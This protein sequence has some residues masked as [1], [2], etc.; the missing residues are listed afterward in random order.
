MQFDP[1]SF[2]DPSGRVFEHDGAVYRTLSP[3]ARQHFETAHGAGLIASLVAAGLLIETDLVTAA[4]LG[5]SAPE[6]GAH[7]LAQPRVPVVT[8]SYEWSFEMLRDAALVTLRVIDRALQSGYILKDATAF[9]VLFHGTQPQFIDIL[10]LEPYE[11]GQ[12]WTGYGQFCRSFLFPLLLA[13]YRDIDVRPLLQGTLGELPVQQVAKLFRIRD[14]VRTGVLKDVVLQSALDRSFAGSQAGVKASTAGRR[15]PKSLLVA[16]VRRLLALIEGLRP[17]SEPGAWSCYDTHHTYSETDRAA[18]SAFVR[19][20][21]MDQPLPRVVDLGCNIGEY[22]DVAL[23]A[24]ASVI[25]LDLDAGAIDR[26]YRAHPRRPQL[27]PVVAT[28]LHPT[29][30]MGWALQERASLLDRI[31][32]DGFL[33]LALVHHLRITGGVPL[34]AI[35]AQL[36]RIAPDGVIEWVDKRDAMVDA[37]AEPEA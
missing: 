37:H 5:L 17:P 16:N 7:V 8:Y 15:Y 14:Y 18:K 19:R 10:S 13:S 1:G 25:A 28:L 36:F 9:N 33:A 22:A 20:A 12:I 29:P 6:V 4:S 23:D 30:S 35:I 2:K 34:D 26:L 32:A 3:T 31:Q 11:D 27:T 24:G 21:L